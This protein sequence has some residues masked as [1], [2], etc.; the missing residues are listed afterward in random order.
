MRID[1]AEQLLRLGRPYPNPS[2]DIVTI[3]VEKISTTGNDAVVERCL[4][5][6]AMGRIVCQAA[7]RPGHTGRSASVHTAHGSFDLDVSG[8]PQG[9]YVASVLTSHGAVTMPVVIAR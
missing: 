6:D 1:N 3:D 5:Y 8:L 9:F 7:Y 2:G 4:L